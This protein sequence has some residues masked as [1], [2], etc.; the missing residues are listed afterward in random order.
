MRC[1]RLGFLLL[2]ATAD[3]NAQSRKEVISVHVKEVH[4]VQ[5][6][7]ATAKG[8]K[9]HITAVVESRTIIYSIKCDEI[10]SPET[11]GYFPQCFR[12]SAG[13]DY[14]VHKSPIGMSFW[15][16]D[17]KFSAGHAYAF[18]DVVSEKEK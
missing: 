15:S 2:L 8:T 5:D 6:G 4:R 9:F 11:R 10:Y 18:Y 1:F 16:E 3:V 12:L 17:T 7:E 13:K 14:P